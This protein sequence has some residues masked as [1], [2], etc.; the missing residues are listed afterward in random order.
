MF[1]H[2]VIAAEISL[3]SMG[4]NEILPI[5]LNPLRRKIQQVSADGAYE[6]RTSDHVLENKGITPLFHIEATRGTGS[7]GIL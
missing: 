3:V 1:T 6:T 5:L 7:N 2:K 4:N